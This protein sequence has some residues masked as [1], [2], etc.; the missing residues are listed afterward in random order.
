MGMMVASLP[1]YSRPPEVC[2]GSD[3]AS[4][5]VLI[6]IPERRSSAVTDPQALAQTHA[7]PPAPMPVP[8]MTTTTTRV[9]ER[10]RVRMV[11]TR[12]ESL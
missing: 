3:S 7:A 11:Q 10:G 6:I 12:T 1:F 9:E 5:Q 2:A 4:A 8:S